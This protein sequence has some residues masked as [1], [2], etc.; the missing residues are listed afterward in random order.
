MAKKSVSVFAPL[1]RALRKAAL[2]CPETM[3]EFPW[4]HPV[5]KVRGK[6]FLMLH[7]NGT[8]LNLTFKLP[9]S[10]M[11]AKELPGVTATGYG[12]GKSGWVT[13]TIG[14]K[15]TPDASM[16]FD[17]MDESFRAVAPKAVVKMLV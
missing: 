2:A 14:L 4:G 5:F 15:D 6:I 1:C 11:F 9:H 13:L 8:E 12:L 16:L 3:E 7:D 10:H 17:W